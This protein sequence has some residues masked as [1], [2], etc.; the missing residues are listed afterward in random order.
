MKI[1]SI[2]KERGLSLEDFGKLL[3]PPADR[4]QVSRWEN[5]KNKPNNERLKS[6]ADIGG[7]SVDELLNGNTEENYFK[8]ISSDEGIRYD[9]QEW[10]NINQ[11]NRTPYLLSL[12]LTLLI[13]I[14][15]N[16]LDNDSTQKVID[17]K[18]LSEYLRNQHKYYEALIDFNDLGDDPL[19]TKQIKKL[20]SKQNNL[21]EIIQKISKLT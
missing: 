4:G 17:I 2:R 13:E 12:P 21:K 20:E 19:T 16:N 8:V 9:K 6:I 3:K 7:I 18:S 1:K 5:N 10:E 14:Y 15:V 11:F